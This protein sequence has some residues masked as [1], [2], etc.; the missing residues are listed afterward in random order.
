MNIKYEEEI[1][2]VPLKVIEAKKCLNITY[3][4]FYVFCFI[5][6]GFFWFYLSSFCAVFQNSQIFIFINA[7]IDF[8]IAALFPFIY[9][10]LPCLLRNTAL[11]NKNEIIFKI[12]KVMQYI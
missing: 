4:S 7:F 11:K 5:F 8:T 9:N 6:I 3:I 10:L 12:S 1:K 2:L